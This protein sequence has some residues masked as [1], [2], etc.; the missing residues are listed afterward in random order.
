MLFL[1]PIFSVLLYFGFHF[2]QGML[3]NPFLISCLAQSLLKKILF[4]FYGFMDL[5][6]YFLLL[7]T[8]NFI[9]LCSI[10]ILQNT[11][12]WIWWILVNTILKNRFEDSSKVPDF[13]S[14]LEAWSWALMSKKTNGAVAR[15]GQ[16]SLSAGVI[17]DR[18]RKQGFYPGCS[19]FRVVLPLQIIWPWKPLTEMPSN[20][21]LIHSRIHIVLAYSFLILSL[22]HLFF[23]LLLKL[24]SI[25]FKILVN[26]FNI[27]DSKSLSTQIQTYLGRE[28][29]NWKRCNCRIGL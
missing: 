16:M 11:S 4:G 7:V 2:S 19:H 5:P 24:V 3:K 27:C 20:L 1:N 13:Q 23:Y 6:E 15:M 14:I 12:P 26:T 22:P 25:F 10:K 18:W 29:V 17:N 8:L 28:N 21:P 9:I